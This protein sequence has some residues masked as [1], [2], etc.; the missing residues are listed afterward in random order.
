LTCGNSDP[1][2]REDF[3]D[4]GDLGVHL[5]PKYELR[6]L[7]EGRSLLHQNYK[8][9]DGPLWSFG[10]E[11]LSPELEF[12]APD[13]SRPHFSDN[14]HAVYVLAADK[15]HTAYWR[16]RSANENSA[17]DYDCLYAAIVNV[18][19]AIFSPEEPL[20]DYDFH[21]HSTPMQRL[22]LFSRWVPLLDGLISEISVKSSFFSFDTIL[23]TANQRYG[24][25]RNPSRGTSRSHSPVSSV[26]DDDQ[27]LQVPAPAPLSPISE[28]L[29]DELEDPEAPQVGME[30]LLARS[31]MEFVTHLP[32]DMR[33]GQLLAVHIV[34]R[35]LVRARAD[36]L[37]WLLLLAQLRQI[38]NTLGS[39][40][41]ENNPYEKYYVHFS[42]PA[43]E[44]TPETL[45]QFFIDVS[46]AARPPFD[47]FAYLVNEA[48]NAGM[49]GEAVHAESSAPDI[50]Q[51]RNHCRQWVDSLI[52]VVKEESTRL[53]FH[54][55]NLDRAFFEKPVYIHKLTASGAASL[56]FYDEMYLRYGKDLE[57]AEYHLREESLDR[58]TA[59]LD[60]KLARLQAL[61]A[62]EKDHSLS[63]SGSLAVKR[64]AD[65]ISDASGF[66]KM[67]LG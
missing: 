22:E 58:L 10:A 53:L 9:E 51:R 29:D 32:A 66:K 42:E 38:Q 34:Y 2:T 54:W 50:L 27:V 36:A 33:D 37:R 60:K 19:Y 35:T 65:D 30:G 11:Q 14:R 56:K 3:L 67:R 21:A 49:I 15:L 4:L 62:V 5:N 61:R 7:K 24:N 1:L 55:D 59:R 64:L 16:A 43:T 25:Y 45:K 23:P 8:D 44:Q 47:F 46:V 28:F 40:A 57:E 48:D 41:G 6:S 39:V 52:A 17:S 12:R 31:H 13:T 63:D 20:R 18:A 26:W